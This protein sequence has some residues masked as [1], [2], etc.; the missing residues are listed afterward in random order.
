[1]FDSK[2]DTIKI[3]VSNT[4]IGRRCHF[5]IYFS[6]PITGA[7]NINIETNDSN[8]RTYSSFYVDPSMIPSSQIVS[9]I[10][11]IVWRYPASWHIVNRVF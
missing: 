8:P 6:V 5:W 1:M 3:D 2:N 9:G 11:Y 10:E 7:I 4:I